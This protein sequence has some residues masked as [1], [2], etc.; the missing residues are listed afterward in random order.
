MEPAAYNIWSV[1]DNPARDK[2]GIEGRLRKEGQ[3][4]VVG[5]IYD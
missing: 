1:D 5:F 3:F 2:G 4:T